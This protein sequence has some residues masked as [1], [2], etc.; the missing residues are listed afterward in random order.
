LSE[1]SSFWRRTALWTGASL[2]HARS[3]QMGV[4]ATMVLSQVFRRVVIAATV[5]LAAP[6]S[7]AGAQTLPGPLAEDFTTQTIGT[8]PANFSTPVGFW[9]IA[10]ADGTKPVLFE[11]GTRW[12]GSQAANNFASQAQ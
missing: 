12:A 2:R 1:A 3:H 9:S 8:D 6:A 5:L 4:N 7:Y 11:D 10:T